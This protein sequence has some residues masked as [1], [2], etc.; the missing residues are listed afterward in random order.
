[1]DGEHMMSGGTLRSLGLVSLEKRRKKRSPTAFL[2]FVKGACR[3]REMDAFQRCK[4]KR[5]WSQAAVRETSLGYRGKNSS[6]EC[7]SALHKVVS[8]YHGTARRLSAPGGR[9][10]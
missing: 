3:K 9:R 2:Y 6:R 8:G 4:D 10:H 1:M 5:W 7:D